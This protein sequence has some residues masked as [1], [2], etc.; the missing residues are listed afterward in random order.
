MGI[1]LIL[2][3][4]VYGEK[5][6]LLELSNLSS[7]SAKLLKGIHRVTLSEMY[8][9]R[10]ALI[11]L[12]TLMTRYT[13]QMSSDDCGGLPEY[14]E[15]FTALRSLFGIRQQRNELREEIQDVL[16]LIET[17]YNEEQRKLRALEKQERAETEARQRAIEK[18]SEAFK[19]RYERFV[20][21]VSSFTVPIVLVSGI[22]GMNVDDLPQLPFWPLL[23]TTTLCSLTLLVIL[24]CI[25]RRP[26]QVDEEEER[27]EDSKR[28][29]AA[30]RAEALSPA[31]MAP[32]LPMSPDRRDLTSSLR[33]Q[34]LGSSTTLC[35]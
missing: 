25:F 26:P 23:G 18:Q 15:F 27:I 16:A 12:A 29:L 30:V 2:S 8:S 32:V 20:T 34:F 11:K 33:T 6:V 22:W 3:A 1:Y 5:S 19:A 7:D 35:S 21:V 4:H 24:I 14:V 28:K 17:N 10:M 13:L 31:P 9:S